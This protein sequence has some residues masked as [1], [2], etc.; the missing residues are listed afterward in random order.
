MAAGINWLANA[1]VGFLYPILDEAMGGYTF[2]IFAG[3]LGGFIF[4]TFVFVPETKGRT[5]A[6]IQVYFGLEVSEKPMSSKPIDSKLSTTET[7]T[8]L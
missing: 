2:F 7:L 1:S 6:D 4:Y 3:L 5:P 8:S